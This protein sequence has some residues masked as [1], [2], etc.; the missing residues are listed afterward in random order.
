MH[1]SQ[2]DIGALV[3]G[4][5]GLWYGIVMLWHPEWI[6]FDPFWRLRPMRDPKTNI[7][8]QSRKLVGSI[9]LACST[10]LLSVMVLDIVHHS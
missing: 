1:F 6:K 8:L 7:Y 5:Y 4:L 3:I 2:Y 10:F 9:S